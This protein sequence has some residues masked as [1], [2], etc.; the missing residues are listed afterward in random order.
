MKLSHA[1][2]LYKTS[3]DYS[4]LS[5]SSKRAYGY[6]EKYLTP[7]LSREISSITRGEIVHWSDSQ[8]NRGS[9][10]MAMVLMRNAMQWVYDRDLGPMPISTQIKSSRQ[11]SHKRWT[12]EEFNVFCE[13]A[14]K[15]VALLANLA[16]YTGQRKS[17]VIRMKWED[18]DGEYIKVVQ[19]KTNKRISI[20]VHENLRRELLNEP[21]Y[22]YSSQN[23]SIST[24]ILRTAR[25]TPW[26][27]ES[28]RRAVAR[29]C[30]KCLPE[31]R[32]IHGLRHTAA[33]VLAELG[34]TTSEIAAITGHS[35]IREVERYTREANQ[36]VMAEKAMRKWE[37]I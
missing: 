25:G 29:V 13:H 6:A 9:A 30:D 26:D 4:A 1:I 19:K 35:N 10:R 18:Y 31:R 20:P 14:P 22:S 32:T 15:H 17:D 36:I 3:P 23:K 34:L 7:F 2:H 37:G 27:E 5:D 16:L 28:A 11:H 8:R 21:L 24:P 33:S 12:M